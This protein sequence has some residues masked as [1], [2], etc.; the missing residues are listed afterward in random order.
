M[1]F[2][3]GFSK[4]AYCIADAAGFVCVSVVVSAI[5]D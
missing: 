3:T 5:Y 1:K 4:S 2:S